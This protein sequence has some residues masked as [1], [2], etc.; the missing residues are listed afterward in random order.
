M[1][2]SE[3]EKYLKKTASKAEGHRHPEVVFPGLH[4]TS[5]QDFGNHEFS[6]NWSPITMP[7]EMVS[8]NHAHDFDQFLFFTGGDGQNMPDLG[9]IVELTLSKDGKKLEKFTIT[10]ATCVFIPAGMYHCPL[11]FVKINDPKKPII[12]SNLYFTANYKK[13]PNKSI[14][15]E[16]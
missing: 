10:E 14:K 13:I 12:F 5:D 4:I 9:G 6:I 1:A 3:L 8:E 16:K 11:K 7:F 15:K 2:K